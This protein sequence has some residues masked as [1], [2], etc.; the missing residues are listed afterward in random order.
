MAR[1]KAQHNANL[2]KH[3]KKK[4]KK[5]DTDKEKVKEEQDDDVEVK[6]EVDENGNEIRTTRRRQR[7]RQ[8][9]GAL[10]EIRRYQRTTELLVQKAPFQ[11]L[12]KT[13]SKENGFEGIRWS[14]QALM[15]LQEAAEAYFTGLCEDAHLCTL[16]GKRVTLMPR[17]MI[18]AN[19]V[20]GEVRDDD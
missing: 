9:A 11:R 15:A 4:K 12:V 18:L 17:D 7:L 2:E 8:G 16:H 1:T 14:S 6:I 13:I 5:K 20:R 3:A 19:R 10:R